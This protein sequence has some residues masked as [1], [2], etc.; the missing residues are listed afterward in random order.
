MKKNKV[1]HK[2][3]WFLKQFLLDLVETL[4]LLFLCLLVLGFIFDIPHQKQTGLT[5][6]DTLMLLILFVCLKLLFITLKFDEKT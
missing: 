4:K 1:D 5:D 3:I 2:F 6:M